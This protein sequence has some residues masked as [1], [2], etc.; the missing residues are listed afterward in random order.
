M[1]L[2]CCDCCRRP[3]RLSQK[4]EVP[5]QDPLPDAEAITAILGILKGSNWA[6]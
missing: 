1:E 2:F 6:A 4:K 5:D 3:S